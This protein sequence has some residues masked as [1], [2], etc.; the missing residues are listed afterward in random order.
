MDDGFFVETVREGTHEDS[1]WLHSRLYL[2]DGN[3][4]WWMVFWQSHKSKDQR[5]LGLPFDMFPVVRYV[6]MVEKVSWVRER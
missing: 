2:K 3:G 5:E 4:Q 1:S 6:E